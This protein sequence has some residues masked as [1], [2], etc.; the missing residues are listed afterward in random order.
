MPEGKQSGGS[1]GVMTPR[2]VQCLPSCHA[3]SHRPPSRPLAG[4][5]D[6]KC[7]A[8]MALGHYA[9][10]APAAFMPYAERSLKVLLAMA[11]YF[12]EALR[13]QVGGGETGRAGSVQVP[14]SVPESVK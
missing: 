4:V 9:E 14:S 1:I 10:A 6:E 11:G 13:R 2:A 3:I 12:H 7:A 5:L 8:A